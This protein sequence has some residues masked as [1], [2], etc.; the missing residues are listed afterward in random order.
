MNPGRRARLLVLG[1]ALLVGVSVQAVPILEEAYLQQAE[2]RDFQ[3]LSEFLTGRENPGNR[4][5]V[6]TRPENRNGTYLFCRF[7]TAIAGFAPGTEIQLEI[8]PSNALVVETWRF[9]L[10][11]DSSDRRR[12]AIGVTGEDWPDLTVSALA[13]RLRALDRQGTILLEEKS[14]LWEA[15]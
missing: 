2:T 3:R 4:L 15:P 7:D 6:R 5:I 13:W 9:S 12:L 8:L 11:S 1:F 10:P 14:Y